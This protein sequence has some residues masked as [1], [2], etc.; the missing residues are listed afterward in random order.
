MD[1]HLDCSPDGRSCEACA[2]RLDGAVRKRS[3]V[4]NRRTGLWIK[5]KTK[6]GRFSDVK[7][8]G[9]KFKG[10]RRKKKR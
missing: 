5:R 7:T 4:K 2:H 1:A 8:S 6:T 3:Q 9:G 10:V